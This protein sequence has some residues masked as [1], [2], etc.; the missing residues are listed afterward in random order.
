MLSILYGLLLQSI[1][2]LSIADVSRRLCDKYF[3]DPPLLVRCSAGGLMFCWLLSVIFSVLIPFGLFKAEIACLLSIACLAAARHCFPRQALS[4]DILNDIT[5][6]TKTFS[7]YLSQQRLLWPSA[8]VFLFFSLLIITRTLALPLMGW[9]TLTYHGVKSGSWVQTGGW[10]MLDAP[11]AWEYYRSFFGG[12]EVFTA[13]SM[14]FLRS[15]VFAGIP[16]VFFWFLSGLIIT[17]LANQSKLRLRT[18]AL[19]SISFLCSFEL[20]RVVGTVYVDTCASSFLLGALLFTLQFLQ[21]GRTCDLYLGFAAFGIASSVKTNALAVSGIMI[22]EITLML[23][24]SRRI[25]LRTY[26]ICAL[27]YWIPVIQWLVFNYQ[28]TGFPLGCVPLSIGPLTLGAMPPSLV[29]F[30]DR[31]DLNPYSF[32]SELSS[33]FLALNGLKFSI[34]LPLLGIAGFIINLRRKEPEY[35]LTAL[36]SFTVVA[37][38]FSPS[39][40][41]IRLEKSWVLV[42]GR[43]LVPGL[44]LL[45]TAGLQNLE[46]FRFG[47]ALIESLAFLSAI[48]GLYSYFQRNIIGRHHIELIFTGIAAIIFLLLCGLFY[49][50]KS[51]SA[52]CDFSQPKYFFLIIAAILG[53]TTVSFHFKNWFR[54]TAYLECRTLQGF[55]KYWNPALV[56]MQEENKSHIAFTHGSHRLG[57]GVMLAQ[58]MGDRFSN[59]LSYISPEKN[60]EVLP[61]HPD[62]F[63]KSEPDFDAWLARLKQ[64]GISHLLVIQLPCIELEWAAKHPEYF[65]RIAGEDEKWGLFR[66]KRTD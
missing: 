54:N 43:F 41:V 61:H 62:Y 66:F 37:L 13:W 20:T 57:H 48:V 3:T 49:W 56:A 59:K 7:D 26:F 21:S 55:G 40:S 42:N 11:G 22:I 51:L 28:I 29:W 36:M 1:F 10:L 18:S 44:V 14:L 45:A 35:L 15:D 32:A 33:L 6:A 65:T 47:P 39:F 19:L 25:T 60:G 58:F 12:G 27:F 16:D 53:I 50:R 23:I 9:D 17:A 4:G 31:P 52:S 30:F 46:K 2:I 8:A 5:A 34:M 38:Y 64:A 63:D 24:K